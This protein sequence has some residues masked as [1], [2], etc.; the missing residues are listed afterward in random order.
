MKLTNMLLKQI[1]TEKSTKLQE[2]GK[3]CFYVEMRA[4]KTGIANEIKKVFGV[5]VIGVQTSIIPERQKTIRGT[6]LLTKK[7]YSKKAT[8]TLKEG[9]KL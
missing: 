3:Y 8:I 1:V 9:Q 6:R 4:T 7:K 2:I 5:D